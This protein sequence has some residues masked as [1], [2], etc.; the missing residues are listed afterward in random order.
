[1]KN[2]HGNV[3]SLVGRVLLTPQHTR[4]MATLRG[5]VGVGKLGVKALEDT[6]RPAGRMA[7]LRPGGMGAPAARRAGGHENVEAM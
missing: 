4:E 6:L 5:V 3:T 7:D 2:R 1:V